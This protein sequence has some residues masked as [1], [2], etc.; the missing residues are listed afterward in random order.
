M[1]Q[2]AEGNLAEADAGKLAAQK[3]NTAAVKEF[4]QEM[5]RD[6]SKNGNDLRR[7]LHRVASCCRPVS[8]RSTRMQ[9]PGLNR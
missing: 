1:T 4:G 6:H 5:A 2:L 3:S 7:S 8:R 9:R